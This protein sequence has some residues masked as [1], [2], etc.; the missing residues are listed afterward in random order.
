MDPLATYH[1]IVRLAKAHATR[2][3]PDTLQYALDDLSVWL[4]TGGYT[5]RTVSGPLPA[6]PIP[7]WASAEMVATI[8]EINGYLAAAAQQALVAGSEG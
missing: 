5:P 7:E 6:I 2:Y 8:R 4:T 1:E 3:H